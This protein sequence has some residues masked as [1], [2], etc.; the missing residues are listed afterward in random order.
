[1]LSLRVHRAYTVKRNKGQNHDRTIKYK[2]SIKVPSTLVIINRHEDQKEKSKV[3]RDRPFQGTCGNVPTRKLRKRITTGKRVERTKTWES[4]GWV[5]LV[6]GKKY[7]RHSKKDCRYREKKTGV[8]SR[9]ENLQVP[10]IVSQCNNTSSDISSSTNCCSLCTNLPLRE[11]H[12]SLGRMSN[13]LVPPRIVIFLM[14]KC[15]YLN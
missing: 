7:V 5:W 14:K 2:T 1:M 12:S 9:G 10:T 3:L 8:R 13:S 15:T 11:C 4:T 6:R